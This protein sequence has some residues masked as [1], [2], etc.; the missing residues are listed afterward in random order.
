MPNAGCWGPTTLPAALAAL[1]HT[2]VFVYWLGGGLGVYIAGDALIDDGASLPARLGAAKTLM[3]IDMAPRTAIILVAPTGLTLA[4]LKGWTPVGPWAI[5]VVWTAFLGWLAVVWIGHLRGGRSAAIA[6]LDLIARW[7]AILGVAAA[8]GLGLS[9][10]TRLPLFI[11]AKLLILAAILM[12]GL[13][14][15]EAVRPM[16]LALVALRAGGDSTSANA[17]LRRV[18][19][20]QTRPIIF[21]IWGLLLTAALLGLWTP[22]TASDHGVEPQCAR[23]LR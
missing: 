5:A 19:K 3:S 7:S 11:C 6:R 14:V 13:L 4:W 18:V 23:Q 21:A 20:R 2:L 8:A 10:K 1:A 22:S 15:R 17:T 12:A 9:G 16:G